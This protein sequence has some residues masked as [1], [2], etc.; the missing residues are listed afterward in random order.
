MKT[1]LNLGSAILCAGLVMA[2]AGATPAQANVIHVNTTAD[3]GGS[4]VC[5]LHDAVRAAVN[6][7][8]VNGCT[9]GSGP[10]TI[11]FDLSGIVTLTETLFITGPDAVTIDGTGRSITLDGNNAVHLIEFFDGSMLNLKTLTLANGFASDGA[12]GAIRSF[13][14]SGISVLN[15]TFTHN[16]SGCGGRS[17]WKRPTVVERR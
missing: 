1:Q 3:P 13:R 2:F 12:G 11:V 6:D 8:A 9:A 15:S 10:D 5:S 14:G 16:I 17:I 4:G 7:S